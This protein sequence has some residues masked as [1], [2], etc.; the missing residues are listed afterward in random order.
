MLFAKHLAPGHNGP[1]QNLQ[2]YG[3][4]YHVVRRARFRFP[5]L[6]DPGSVV[7][8]RHCYSCVGVRP[9][10]GLLIAT[11][12]SH[13]FLFFPTLGLVALAAFYLPS[14]AFVDMYWRHVQLGGLRFVIG[15]AALVALSAWISSELLKSPYRSVWE[16]SPSVL[17]ADK[18]SPQGCS[19]GGKPCD[20]IGLMEGLRNLAAVSHGRLGLKPF[21]RTCE[22]DA[23]IE[24]T[25]VEQ[26]RFCFAS[27][28]LSAK[29]RLTTD[30]ECCRAQESYKSTISSLYAAEDN[31][32]LTGKVL[33]ALLPAKV[34]FLL[35]LFAIS[36]LLAMRHA[37]VARHYPEDVARIE[38]GV[39][40][41]AIAMMF[42]PLMSQGFVEST[43][44]L[45]GVRQDA[46][47]KPIV[48]VMS[49]LFG[50]WTLLIVLFFFRRYDAKTDMAV[51]L[52]GV[53]LSGLAV[54]KYEL[55]TAIAVRFLG[56]EPVT[57]HS[58]SL[59]PFR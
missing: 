3:L 10:D 32:S 9:E 23:L 48:P 15:L 14:C 22:G 53:G 46:G 8:R 44:A 20:R 39:L 21:V 5:D 24:Q 27:T 1:K 51:K 26:K 4:F 50:T 19:E 35:V 36:V 57:S 2:P 33:A 47:F 42:F 18:G 6:Y 25:T 12:D 54:V 31:H 11:S 58:F 52:A 29:P 43:N 13:L 40:V 49:V 56:S 7:H 34:F 37:G 55:I 30:A 16:L 17:A 59:S 38:V 28:P 41:G 45:F